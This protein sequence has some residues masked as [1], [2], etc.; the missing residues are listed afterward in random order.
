[1]A[2]PPLRVPTF[3]NYECR[4]CGWCCHQY[5]ITVSREDKERL[6][7]Y[8]WAALEPELSGRELFAAVRGRRHRGDE[9]RL[10]YTPEGA[11]A[12][13]SSE[14]TC[15]MHRHVGELGKPLGCCVFPLTFASTPTG[16]YVGCRFSC[17]AVAYGM[18]DPLPRKSRF[19][20]RQID[21]VEKAGHLPRYPDIV[22][23]APGRF[24]PWDDYIR[25]EEMAIRIMLREDIALLHR[26]LALHDIIEVLKRANFDRLRGERFGELLHIL[27]EGLPAEAGRENPR[28]RP[29]PILRMIFRQ[30]CFLFQNRHG[31]AYHEL[32]P[33]GRLRAR[34]ENLA[35]SLRFTFNMGRVRPAAFPG[36]FALADV[37]TIPPPPLGPN[38]E[39]AI[40]RFLAAKM[41]G[42][43]HFGPL[44]FRYPVAD[45]LTFL[46]L[47][48]GAVLWYAR[49][50]ALARGTKA[51]EHRD[52]IEAI[53][54]VDFCY[55]FSPAPGLIVE[56]IRVKLLGHGDAA[57]RLAA[58][59]FVRPAA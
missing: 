56:R 11:C 39:L 19:M 23:I 3:V 24:L 7:A 4:L 59:Q 51:P 13:L 16:V 49:A 34:L 27:E 2:R 10:H 50:L 32:G 25:L 5:D 29:D 1:M 54:Y 15:L 52:V 47:A 33:V 53:R 46:L 12:F 28:R 58:D 44:F 41:F 26:L 18:G 17:M 45:G 14:N 57:M 43:Q 38:E 20:E 55:G 48:A 37:A 35:R 6:S 8:D 42:K 21:L 36:E 31:G 9:F 30:F 40:S 22:V